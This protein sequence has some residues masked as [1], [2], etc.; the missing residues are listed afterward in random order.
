MLKNFFPS[1][2]TNDLLFNFF[3]IKKNFGEALNEHPAEV[4][5][6]ARRKKSSGNPVF[7][8]PIPQKMSHS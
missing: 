1:E 8:W 6:T 3:V 2:K 7:C 4:K 5:A